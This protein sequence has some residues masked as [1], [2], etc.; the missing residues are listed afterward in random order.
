MALLDF[1]MLLTQAFDEYKKHLKLLVT[2]SFIIVFIPTIILES[3]SHDHYIKHTDDDGNYDSLESEK[4]GFL[5]EN[6]STFLNIICTM[7]LTITVIKILLV[8]RTRKHPLS[9]VDAIREGSAHYG[10]GLL[11]SMILAGAIFALTL[12]LIIPGIIFMVYWAFSYYAL[13][14][15]GKDIMTSMKHSKRV[16]TGRWWKVF[17]YMILLALITF[18]VYFG[19]IILMIPIS[20]TLV[21]LGLEVYAGYIAI[22]ALGIAGLFVAPF[23]V[24]FMEKFYLN[25]K[26]NTPMLDGIPPNTPENS[27]PESVA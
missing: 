15:D 14:T 18:S 7:L 20:L 19:A 25:L 16:V 27:I 26:E 4:K 1:G 22:F 9:A 23:S 3:Y 17:G 8:K 2:V 5:L 13:I 11:L 10:E 6:A 24:V 12:L 21:L